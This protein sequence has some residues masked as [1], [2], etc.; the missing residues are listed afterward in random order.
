MSVL[1]RAYYL[2]LAHKKDLINPST[3]LTTKIFPLSLCVFVFSTHVFLEAK[4]FFNFEIGS[5]IELRS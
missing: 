4:G 1:D 5:L 3:S 2:Y